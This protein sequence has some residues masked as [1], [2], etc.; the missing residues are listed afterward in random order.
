MP[1]VF[2]V[3]SS[4]SRLLGKGAYPRLSAGCETEEFN[5]ILRIQRTP[6]P[7]GGTQRSAVVL[8]EH[9][10]LHEAQF[11]NQSRDILGARFSRL[12]VESDFF[13]DAVMA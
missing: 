13:Q 4:S 9:G 1:P 8:D 10:S 5:A 11:G 6:R 12:P 7:F 2:T 3:P